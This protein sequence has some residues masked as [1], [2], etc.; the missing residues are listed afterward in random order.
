MRDGKVGFG[1][2]FQTRSN[3]VLLRIRGREGAGRTWQAENCPIHCTECCVLVERTKA[4]H[5]QL[6]QRSQMGV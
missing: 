5:V 6:P 3:L 4:S 1:G 2:N